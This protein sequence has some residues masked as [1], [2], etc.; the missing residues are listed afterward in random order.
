MRSALAAFL[1]LLVVS[2]AYALIGPLPPPCVLV[3]HQAKQCI[4]QEGFNFES[5]IQYPPAFKREFLPTDN[6]CYL[7]EYSIATSPYALSE[8]WVQDAKSNNCSAYPGFSKTTLNEAK[9]TTMAS[10]TNYLFVMLLLL[11]P[12]LIVMLILLI[13]FVRK[14]KLSKKAPVLLLI[15]GLLLLL[16]LS[17]ANTL[18]WAFTMSSPEIYSSPFATLSLLLWI[19][20]F[21]IF[22][23]QTI[24][25]Q[26]KTKT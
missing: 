8:D 15:F 3:N 22:V 26:A 25:R 19:F 20:A 21:L 17:A 16:N 18:I 10:I 5:T 1:V 14:K 9:I 7:P 24:S 12:S 2:S 13:V 4:D 23:A 11:A 6:E